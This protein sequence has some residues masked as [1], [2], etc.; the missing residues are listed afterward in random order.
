MATLMTIPADRAGAP[1]SRCP[2]LGSETSLVF[3][4]HPTL[5]EAEIDKTCEVIKRVM[6]GA[7]APSL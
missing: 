6:T 3:L 5:T 4:C 2:S 1:S 7:L